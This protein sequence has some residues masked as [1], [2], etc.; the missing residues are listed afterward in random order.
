MRRLFI[1][2]Q[3]F[4]YFV[5]LGLVGRL[6]F[7]TFLPNSD[8]SVKEPPLIFYANPQLSGNGRGSRVREGEKKIVRRNDIIT[9]FV[10]RVSA[11]EK[12]DTTSRTRTIPLPAKSASGGS[13]NPTTISIR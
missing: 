10:I 13:T 8:G 6:A 4:H 9:I 2:A 7:A 3:L 12:N 5:I 1:G 11:P